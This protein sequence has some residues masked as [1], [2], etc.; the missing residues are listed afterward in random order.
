VV[1]ALCGAFA[2]IRGGSRY[3]EPIIRGVFASIPGAFTIYAVLSP[4]YYTRYVV[5]QL[6]A[7]VQALY[8][9]L[10]TLYAMLSFNIISIFFLVCNDNDMF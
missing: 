8:A 1:S 5:S 3:F 10:L 2:N 9:V 6:H 7:V 4:F